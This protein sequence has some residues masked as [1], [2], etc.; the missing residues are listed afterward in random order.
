MSDALITLRIWPTQVALRPTYGF[1]LAVNG[2]PIVHDQRLSVAESQTLRGLIHQYATLFGRAGGAAGALGAQERAVGA[3]LFNLWFARTWQQIG[4]LLPPDRRRTLLIEA[5]APDILHLPWALLRPPGHDFLCNDPLFALCYRPS[6]DAVDDKFPRAVPSGPLKLLLMVAAPNS[7]DP[8]PALREEAAL[9]RSVARANSTIVLKI[10][11][12]GTFKELQQ[13]IRAM[14]PTMLHLVGY[15]R[16]GRSCSSCRVVGQA[17]D[18]GCRVCGAVLTTA[19]EPFFAFEDESGQI[20][21]QS[22]AMI[23]E[24]LAPHRDLQ[25]VLVSALHRDGPPPITAV[26][27]LCRSIASRALPLVVGWACSLTAPGAVVFA[28]DV[29]RQLTAGAVIDA[30]VAHAHI[31]RR[32]AGS[33][34]RVLT[35]PAPVVYAAT[36]RMELVAPSVT[37]TDQEPPATLALRPLPGATVGATSCFVGRRAEMQRLTPALLRGTTQTL[38]L[39]GARG[40]GKSVLATALARLLAAEGFVPVPL[41]STFHAPLT[42]ARLLFTCAAALHRHDP[43][44]VRSLA[45]AG[46]SLS[47]R[48]E[49]LLD[50]LARQRIVLLLDRFDVN[51]DP[52]TQ[53]MKDPWL[54]AV[55]DALI[56]RPGAQRRVLITSCVVPN[57]FTDL[58]ATSLVHP[59]DPFSEEAFVR[60]L[61]HDAVVARRFEAGECTPTLLSEV[62]HRL[63]G[64]PQ[65][66]EQIRAALRRFGAEV[67]HLMCETGAPSAARPGT[68]ALAAIDPLLTRL[69]ARLSVE[70]QHRLQQAAVYHVPVRLESMASREAPALRA[71]AHAHAWHELALATPLGADLWTIAE[72]LRPWLLAPTRFP[73]VER[74]AAH[75]AAGDRLSSDLRGPQA[76]RRGVPQLDGWL[77][78]RA[79]YIA[80]TDFDHARAVTDRLSQAFARWGLQDEGNDLQQQLVRAGQR[81]SA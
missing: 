53:R 80:A 44:A 64:V 5:D 75:A 3:A 34:S 47:D 17:Y 68:A 18:Q 73:V 16:L 6:L 62:Y 10:A 67:L 25:C 76:R 9:L 27:D 38:I 49:H 19:A 69:N 61:L 29:Y 41:P 48:L 22:G 1:R 8:R 65:Y 12:L 40:S 24:R 14:Q 42:V 78:V 46:R 32:A 56:A 57:E 21:W 31:A 15:T 77:E 79:Q 60:F 45:D 52:V 11:E 43:S 59:L 26:A 74:Q 13:Q 71:Q 35:W 33:T 55:C 70:A 63:G 54:A 7:P 30:A 37:R 4:A 23:R 50:L 66:A 51:L 28:G 81:P 2:F 58:P 36:S 72:A 39:T 20:D